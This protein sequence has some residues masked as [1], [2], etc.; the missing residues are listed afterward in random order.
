M[1]WSERAKQIRAIIFDVDGVLTD[2]R[3][4]YGPDGVRVKFFNVRDGTAIRLAL[5]AGLRVGFLSGRSDPGTLERAKELRVSFVYTGSTDKAATFRRLL[6]EHSLE[7][8]QCLYVGDDDDVLDAPAL[9]SAGIGVVVAD[10]A[11]EARE[12]ADLVLESRGGTG[13]ARETVERLLRAQG[14]WESALTALLA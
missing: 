12:A 1:S 4:G 8:E 11:P 3:V 9:A 10:A 6:D 14:C 2:G 7:A 5:A 13:A